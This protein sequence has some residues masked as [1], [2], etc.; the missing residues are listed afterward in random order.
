[1]ARPRSGSTAASRSSTSSGSVSVTTRDAR[2]YFIG[3]PGPGCGFIVGRH[4]SSNAAPTP[5]ELFYKNVHRTEFQLKNPNSCVSWV[6][7][8]VPSL[9]ECSLVKAVARAVVALACLSL[10]FCSSSTP[11]SP[12]AGGPNG[13]R[14]TAPTPDSP[15]DGAPAGSYRPTLVVKN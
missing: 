1:M 6:A 4:S 13:P 14:L 3:R 7:P 5:R 8:G 11:L 9:M 10:S 12:A 15:A 2:P